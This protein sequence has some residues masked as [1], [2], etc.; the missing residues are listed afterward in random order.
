MLG[1]RIIAVSPE[2]MERRNGPLLPL[3]FG[4]ILS[5]YHSGSYDL[6]GILR[7]IEGDGAAISNFV[8]NLATV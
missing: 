1:V 2:V 4:G 7:L 6:S 8:L 5:Q 3:V